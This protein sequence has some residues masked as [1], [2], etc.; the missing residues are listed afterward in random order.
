VVKLSVI[1]CE[2]TTRPVGLRLPFRYG[3]VTLRMAQE[4]QV[5][6]DVRGENG[7]TASGVAAELLAPKW[8][9]KSPELSSDDNVRQLLRSVDLALGAY[10]DDTEP[11]TAFDLHAAHDAEHRQRCAV[12][13]L[14][15]LVAGF[16]NAVV[17]KAVISALCKLF[18]ASF[19]DVVGSNEIGLTSATATDLSSFDLGTFLAGLHASSAILARH[20]VGLVDAIHEADIAPDA[21]VDDGLP[22]SLEGAIAQWSLRAFKI[23]VG[24]DKAAD[25]DRLTRIASILDRIEKPYL[26]TLDGNEQYPD[27]G[28]F[29]DFFR[30]LESVP[31]LDRLRASIALIEQPIARAAALST[32]LGELGNKLSVEIDE[33][34]DGIDAFLKARELGYRGVS[35]KSCKGVYRAL[36]NAARV[37]QW[38]DALGE[39]R[40]FLSA[41]DLSTQPGLALQQDLS[42]AAMLGCSHVERNG[43]Y[44]GDG[45]TGLPMEKRQ[46]LQEAFG[47]L[48]ENDDSA[49]RLRIHEGTLDLLPLGQPLAY[50][51]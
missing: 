49:L 6:V 40:Y 4:V 37:A 45:R 35:S 16:G 30:A 9:D 50:G 32:S 10:I 51:A 11:R 34:D 42:L 47:G 17:D 2:V 36:L 18:D 26:C 21:R 22:E 38:N 7:R 28:A 25:I 48:Y 31:R 41:E 15:G 1:A 5:T 39:R 19:F 12:E 3:I 43:H 24:G 23:K 29:F 13:G 27:V 33:S 20:T 8:F 44:Y 46:R 14:N